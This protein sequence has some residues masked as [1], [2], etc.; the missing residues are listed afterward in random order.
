[1]LEVIDRVGVPLLLGVLVGVAVR[2]EV[3]D[4]EDV[5]E[6]LKLLE[7]VIEL[8]IDGVGVGLRVFVIEVVGV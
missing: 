3:I 6:L 8:V 2:L 5:T 1:M 7:G 4:P